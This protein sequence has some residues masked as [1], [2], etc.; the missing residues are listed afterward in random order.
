MISRPNHR[1][2]PADEWGTGS[3]PAS[4]SESA[5]ESEPESESEAESEA[6]RAQLSLAAVEAGIGVL[7]ILTVAAVFGLG[8]PA[9]GATEAQLDA[10]AED[11]A[12]V[13]ANEPP[14]HAG[15][16]RLAEVAQSPAA[17]E[18]EREGLD[19]RV[20]RILPANL[21]YRIET[22]HGSVGFEQPA[23]V[24]VGRAAVPTRN[25]TVSITVWYA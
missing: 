20:D 23:G 16:T 5:S 21:L 24:A 4:E 8:L 19:R 3:G 6:D 1:T 10:Y 17:L 18:R 9:T 15:E 11:T 25:G 13:L 14:R 7:F 22:P 12:T 2:R